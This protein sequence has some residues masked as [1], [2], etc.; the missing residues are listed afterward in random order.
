MRGHNVNNRKRAASDASGPS[1]GRKRPRRAAVRLSATALK[2]LFRIALKLNGQIVAA[3]APL[4]KSPERHIQAPRSGREGPH[5]PD[6]VDQH[7]R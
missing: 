6:G 2:I 7:S 1:L 3:A 4:G 5:G